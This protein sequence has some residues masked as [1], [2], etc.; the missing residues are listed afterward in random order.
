MS[1]LNASSNPIHPDSGRRLITCILSPRLWCLPSRSQISECLPTAVGRYCKG[2]EVIT[3]PVVMM[4]GFKGTRNDAVPGAYPLDLE[5]N[6]EQVK[7]SYTNS[8]RLKYREAHNSGER[9]GIEIE[10]GNQVSGEPNEIH[11]TT[12]FM[13]ESIVDLNGPYSLSSLTI[14][15]PTE[16]SCDKDKYPSAA[17]QKANP[18]CVLRTISANTAVEVSQPR[19]S[20]K[21]VISTSALKDHPDPVRKYAG[22]RTLRLPGKQLQPMKPPTESQLAIRQIDEELAVEASQLDE[23]CA[24]ELAGKG[25][26]LHLPEAATA[27]PGAM[28]YPRTARRVWRE[29]S[30]GPVNPS[31]SNSHSR[32]IPTIQISKPEDLRTP[33]TVDRSITDQKS[34]DLGATP[35]RQRRSRSNAVYI[36][37]KFQVSLSVPSTTSH[38]DSSFSE[39]ANGR[40]IPK[41]S[42][43]PE[44]VNSP[45]EIPADRAKCLSKNRTS[46][47][48]WLATISTGNNTLVADHV[49]TKAAP[50]L[51]GSLIL[52][53]FSTPPLSPAGSASSSDSSTP[54]TPIDDLFL[55]LPLVKETKTVYAS[56]DR[57]RRARRSYSG[58]EYEVVTAP[59]IPEELLTDEIGVAC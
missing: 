58:D 9:S 14:V 22:M 25:I 30:I 10:Y 42:K 51:R 23:Y 32:E 46:M 24:R 38:I 1:M 52:S 6:E 48:D 49:A 8:E 27:Q 3:K 55:P 36:P 15:K 29:T 44:P 13:E 41:T 50:V 47:S 21:L 5:S 34:P 2:L 40:S 28:A 18:K 33:K 57:R 39:S 45:T 20:K 7:N 37:S 16:D 19:P 54:S 35:M 43:R 11:P 53:S 59:V 31:W 4:L 26:S 17:N 56:G 12:M